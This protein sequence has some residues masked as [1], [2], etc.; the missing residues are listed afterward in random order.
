MTNNRSTPPVGLPATE[1]STGAQPSSSA[2]ASSGARGAIL[3]AIRSHALPPAPQPDFAGPWIEYAD[4]LTQFTKVLEGIG[5]RVHHVANVAA[6][7][8]I[9]ADIP[10]LASAK[11]VV[12]LA[13]GAGRTNVDLAAIDD[14]HQLADIDLAIL[15]G[16]FGV[17]ENG[18]I[19]VTSR[20]VRHRALYIIT[21]HLALVIAAGDLVSNMC[22]AYARAPVGQDDWGAFLAGP[23]KTADIE[24]SLVIGAHGPRS[25]D[26]F[27][28]DQV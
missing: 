6:I 25:L 14:P 10:E 16:A 18:S 19:W 17:A 2:S 27:L 21:Q 12:S 5:A 7:D 15:P 9:L 1:S 23:S 3:A 13:P 11:Q 20:G 26:V 8:A 4:R 22:E 24:Q 28:L